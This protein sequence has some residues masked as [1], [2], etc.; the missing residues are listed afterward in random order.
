[1]LLV[2]QLSDMEKALVIPLVV[3]IPDFVGKTKP[4]EGD[5]PGN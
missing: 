2:G 3:V 1:M 5:R 4:S